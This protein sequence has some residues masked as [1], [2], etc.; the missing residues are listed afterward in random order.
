MRLQPPLGHRLPRA[1]LLAA[2]LFAAAAA[3]P[4]AAEEVVY[5]PDGAPTV[6]QHKLYP[7]SG[8]WEFAFRAQTAINDPLVLHYG[9]T[10]SLSYH[11]NEWFDAGLDVFGNYTALANLASV[12]RQNLSSGYRN[13]MTPKDEIANADQLR[14]GGLL[15]AR[16][17]P[18]YGKINLASELNVHFQTYLLLG[19][20]AT[21]IHHESVNLCGVN[22]TTACPDGDYQTTDSFTFVGEVGGGFRF[23]F[24]DKWSLSTEVRAYLF[25]A[26]YKANNDLTQAQSGTPTTYLGDLVTFSLG[27]GRLF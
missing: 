20:G 8:Q 11:P 4:A 12:V 18:I 19:A 26:S 17:A 25:P 15:V 10:L 24:S 9:A 13:A 16:V 1:A 14:F 3:R 27:I 7:M 21:Q 23:Y 5:G 6:L 22:G 2:L